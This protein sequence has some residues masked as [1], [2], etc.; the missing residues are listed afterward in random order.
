MTVVYTRCA[1]LDVHK[2]T[3]SVCV[4]IA[5]GKQVEQDAGLF[6]TFTEDLI[7]LAEFLRKH[8][9]RHVVMESTGVYWV[10]VWNVLERYQEWQ[11]ELVLV[12]PQHVRALPGKKTDQQDAERLA[13][14]GQYNLL[15]AS[16]I[17]PLAQRQLRDLTRQRAHLQGD[18]NRVI[19]RIQRWLEKA[20]IKLSSVVSNLVGKTGLLILVAIANGET[21]LP[22]LSRLACG[23]L[24]GKQL[25]L[26]KALNGTTDDHFRWML[27]ELLDEL[28]RLDQKLAS[29]N[30]RIREAVEPWSEL[31]GRLCTI[32][33]V[34]EIVAWTLLAE[35]GT[36]MQQFA[37]A[38]HAASWAGLCPG[39]CESA[40]KRQTGRTRKGN[41]Y[42]RR[43][44][45][46][47]G[48]AAARTKDCFLSDLF[49]RIARRRGMKRAALAVAHRILVIAYSVIRDH[50][51]YK[52]R[53]EVELDSLRAQQMARKLT[54]RLQR[55]GYTVTLARADLP[56]PGIGPGGRPIATPQQC[57]KCA[58]WGIPCVHVRNILGYFQQPNSTESGV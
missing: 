21:E 37:T 30:H 4:R 50:K 56:V 40:G 7:R 10:P 32:P 16:F 26:K 31:I 25:E 51:V 5:K 41:A 53:N 8:K 34:E 23:S 38:G 29:L 52:E 27:K 12:N 42:L 43:A 15:S 28:E 58:R 1:G 2:K 17:P 57:S 13:E 45:V 47:S 46:Q 11:F 20:N 39:N 35:L 49:Y 22:A 48:W 55:I 18:R 3:I 14:L 9:V 33:G 54:K 44:L 24:K 6:G 36:D 19:G